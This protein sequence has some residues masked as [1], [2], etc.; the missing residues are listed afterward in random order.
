MILLVGLISALCL[1]ASVAIPSEAEFIQRN[2]E[3]EL[4]YV[5]DFEIGPMP[6]SEVYALNAILNEQ[7]YLQQTKGII[8][9]I[10]SALPAEIVDRRGFQSEVICYAQNSQ[11]LVFRTAGNSAQ[12]AQNHAMNTCS[13]YR[14]ICEPL[15]C[16]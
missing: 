4:P 7:M 9:Q 3:T 15:G 12:R 1:R 13:E 11:G 10:I 16:L 6:G 2:L 14:K 8:K 5:Y